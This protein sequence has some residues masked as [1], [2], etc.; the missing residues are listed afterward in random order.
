MEET[1]CRK[2]KIANVISVISI[3][4]IIALI[5]NLF[6]TNAS[7]NKEIENLEANNFKMQKVIDDLNEKILIMEEKE[8]EESNT[9]SNS[10]TENTTEV[11]NNDSEVDNLEIDRIAGELFDKGSQ[12]VRE[13]IY[14]SYDQ[15]SLIIP[16]EEKTLDKK[17][18]EKRNVLYSSVE[19]EFTS[20]F[21][22]EA[23]EV[24]LKER[25]IEADDG[26]LYVSTGGQDEWSISNVT[27]E[28]IS[29][30]DEN[31][32]V[33]YKVTYKDVENDGSVS[34]DITCTMKIKLVDGEYKI[35]ETN[36]CELM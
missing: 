26:Y 27:L 16:S 21:T 30:A 10:I 11:S 2:I 9:I 33:E 36:Y 14:S 35:S 5:V 1:K 7:H 20:I 15:Y 17:I 28:R 34:E 8:V 23:L 6:M 29:K 13:I 31:D 3:L 4:I 19:G 24:A 18:Y 12:K 25:F 32:E 22:G